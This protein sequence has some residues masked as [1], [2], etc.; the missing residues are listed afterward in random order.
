MTTS[1]SIASDLG[2]HRVASARG[3]RVDQP[4]SW[5]SAIE[6]VVLGV[7]TPG[8]YTGGE[9][10]MCQPDW[11]DTAQVRFALA[12]P[13]TYAIGMS[14]QGVKILYHLVNDQADMLCERAF[15]PWL[16]M[17]AKMRANGIPA[18]SLETHRALRDF[19]CVGFSLQNETS[20]SNVLNLIDLGGVTVDAALRGEHEPIVIAGGTGSVTPEP[21]ADF[22]DVFFIGEGEEVL[23]CFLRLLGGWLGRVPVDAM[24]DRLKTESGKD[25]RKDLMSKPPLGLL[26]GLVPDNLAE[27]TRAEFIRLCATVIPGCY[28]P[29][30]YEVEHFDDGRVKAVTKR[31]DAVPARVR[32]NAVANLNDTYFPTKQILPYIETVHDRVTVE[33]MRGCTEGCRYCQAGMIDRPQRYRTPEKVLAMVRE[34]LGNTGYDEVSLLSLSSSDH[35]QLFDIMKLVSENFSK[36]QVSLSLPS[37]RVD[38]QLRDLPKL[39][40]GVR[41]S[42]LTLAPE[43]GSQRLRKVINKSITQEDLLNGA[44][45]AFR[46]GWRTVKFYCM[47]GLPTENDDDIRET[48]DLLN[49]IAFMA[50]DM[51]VR[52]TINVTVSLFVPK[53]FTPFQWEPMATEEELSHRRRLLLSLIRFNSIKLKFHGYG[54]SWLEALMSRG[55]RRLGRVIRRAW[56][57]GARFDAWGEGFKRGL[58]DQALAE[59]GL[60]PHFYIHRER[61]ADEVLPWDMISVGVNKRTLWEERVRSRLEQF[62]QDCSGHTPGCLACGVDP[63]TCRTGIDQPADNMAPEQKKRA[64]VIY[65]DVFPERQKQRRELE[66]AGVTFFGS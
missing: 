21:L 35:P 44:E 53:A 15:S 37:L 65:A 61:G 56:E 33:I 46:E 14:N 55:D 34:I 54:E 57:L 17:E 25:N 51:R 64:G 59:S 9:V 30:L 36:D 4:Q 49:R 32:K 62:T 6:R 2:Q 26:L 3:G 42:G 29:S 18:F 24:R 23:P 12:F 50:K 19:D 52:A 58:W 66:A 16:D 8:Q 27:L 40:R 5:Y 7:E 60:D 63:L 47:I 31:V 13:D 41:R 1:C 45:T 39:S 28:A 43:T 48:A 38:Q 22:V 10:N 20:Y 11:S